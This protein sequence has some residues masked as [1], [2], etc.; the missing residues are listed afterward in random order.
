MRIALMLRNI[1]EQGG[2]GE[3]ARQISQALPAV[4]RRNDYVLLF[5]SSEAA[6]RFTPDRARAVVVPKVPG[7]LLWDQVAVPRVL[8]R[9]RID[10]VVGGKHSIPLVTSARKVFI[11]HGADW[12]SFRENYTPL[13]NLYHDLMLPQYLRRADQVITVSHD[14]ARRIAAYRPAV[15]DR[16][17]VVYHGVSPHLRPVTD[18]VLLARTRAAYGLPERFL[19]FVGQIYRQKNLPGILRALARLK[20]RIP[21]KLVI[22]GRASLKAEAEL[23]WIDRLGLAPRVQPIGWIANQD[24]APLYSL[25]DALVFPS[26]WEGFGIP[27]IEAMA[28]GCPV[29]TSSA[30][31]CAEVAGD[32]GLVVDPHDDA[33]L[34]QAIE[35]VATQAGLA[36][37]LRRRGL[38]RARRFTWE[39]TAQGTAAVLEAAMGSRGPVAGA[40]LGVAPET[41]R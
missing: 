22:A 40:L 20:E 10:V 36:R 35:R 6:R 30:G 37:E 39:Q 29:V 14:S 16:L 21:H 7:K 13:D 18:P 25:A 4:D 23:A 32:A 2:A 5:P 41:E 31:S 12:I 1:E 19:L 15:R 8:A 17:W 11:M 34:A 26:L 9:E 33:A 3:Y 38:E 27:I 28:C 24:L